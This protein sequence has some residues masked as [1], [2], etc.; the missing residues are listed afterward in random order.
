[1]SN[2]VDRV[3][4]NL[5]GSEASRHLAI[6]QPSV[7]PIGGVKIHRCSGMCAVVD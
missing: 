6:R 5:G 2:G 1:M 7:T 3:C 4:R